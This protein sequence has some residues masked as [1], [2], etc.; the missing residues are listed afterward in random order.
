MTIPPNV[1]LL[2]S[3]RRLAQEQTNAHSRKP[4]LR[5]EHALGAT[6]AINRSS[7]PPLTPLPH[8]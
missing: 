3:W 6:D 2:W 1:I 5:R 8:E 4:S 7:L